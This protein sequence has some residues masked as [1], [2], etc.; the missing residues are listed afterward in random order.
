MATPAHAQAVKSL[1]NSGGRR[2]FVF[3]SFSQK[4]E[5]VE[6]DVYKSLDK[7]KAE[8]SEGSCFFLDCLTEWRELNTAEDFI[9]FYEEMVPLVQTLPL[10]LLHKESIMSNLLSRLQMKARL[11]VEPILRLIAAL[12]RDLLE[13]FVPFLPNIVESVVSLLESGADMEP[14]IIE[15]IFTSLSYIM[16]YLQKYLVNNLVHV[17]KV[18]LKLRYYPKDY[19]QDFMAEA[20]S[21]LLRNAPFDQLKQGVWKIMYEVVKKPLPARKYGVSVLLCYVMR[22]SSSKFHSKAERVLR[23]LMSDAVL[24]I[25]DKFN[26]GSDTV[27]EFNKNEKEGIVV[28]VLILAFQRLCEVIE[29]KDL[30]LMWRCLYGE[31]TNSVNNKYFMRLSCLL[32]L[33]ISTAQIN[34]RRRVSDYL[35][36]LDVVESTLNF[37]TLPSDI[38]TAEDH[39]HEVFEKVLQLMLR[40]LDVLH[41]YNDMPKISDSSVNWA[42]VFEFKNSSLLPSIRE[43]LSKD[44]SILLSFIRELLSK[45]PC[46]L[47]LFR[48]NVLRA[49]NDLIETL[50]GEIS[51]GKEKE[52]EEV[53]YLLLSFFKRQSIQGKNF[54]I[55]V[56]EKGLE[57]IQDFLRSDICKWIGKLNDILPRDL[58]SNQDQETE[59]ALLWGAINCA[60]YLLDPQADS[61]LIINLMDALDRCLTNEPGRVMGIP[62]YH[63]QSIIGAALSCHSKL[64]YGDSY[65]FEETSKFVHLA[66]RHKSCLQVV[67]AVA[68]FLDSVYG[69]ITE[70]CCS[71]RTYHPELKEQKIMDALSLFSNNL[72]HSEKGLRLA[73]LR[74][75]CHYEPL[76]CNNSTED[77]PAQKKMKTESSQSCLADRESFNVLQL[78]LEIEKTP[79]SVS[80]SRTV[81]LLI[82]RVQMALSVGRIPEAYVPLLLNGMI[83]VFHNRFS[84]I[85]TPASEC[86]AVLVSQHVGL[87]WDKFLS[88][89]EQMLSTFQASNKQLDKMNAKSSDESSDLVKQFNSFVTPTSDST[90][91]TTVLTLLLQVLQR[92]PTIVDAR[93]RQIV[94]LFLRFLGYNCDEFV[95]VGSFNTLVC[96]GKEWKSILKEWL[97]LLKLMRNLRS[98]YRNQFLKDLL[99]NRLLDENDPQIQVKVLDCLLIWKDDFLLPYDQHLKN[100]L[101]ADNSF[102]EELT[103]WSLSRESNLIEEH[104]RAYLVPIVIRLL[105]PKVRK[106]KKHDSRKHESRKAVLGFIAHLE[107]DE[108]PLFFVLLIKPLQITSMGSDGT[109]DLLWTSPTSSRDR[110]QASNFLDYFTVDNVVALSWK[111]RN[112][113]LHVI[114]DVIG[115]FDEFR[116]IPFLD[117]LMGCVVRILR[118][119]TSCIDASK[120]NSS[121]LDEDQHESN[122]TLLEKDGAERNLVLSFAALKQ[123]KELRSLCLKVVSLVLN[124]YEDHDFGYEFWDLFFKSVKPLVDNFQQEGSSAEKPSSLF[125]CFVAMTR[126]QKLV[127]MLLQEKNLVP[128]IFSILTVT[129][130]SEDI[131][132]C[133]LKFIEN[134]LNL[135]SELDDK[136]SDVKRVLLPNLESLICSLH[137]FFQSDSATK[138]ELVKCP[139]QTEMRIFKLLSKYIKDPLLAKKFVDILLPFLAKGA[140]NSEIC[141]EAAQVIRGFIPVLGGQITKTILKAVSPLFI[142][143]GRETR[144][145]LC[146]LLETLA[147]VDPSIHNVAKHVHDLN[148]TSATEVG[149]LDYDVIINAY[150]KIN[151]DFFYTVDEDQALVILSHCVYDMSSEE[152]IL[153]HSAY[154]L[155][156]L[157][158]EFSAL[159]LSGDNINPDDGNWTK[160]SL[161]RIVRNFFL[162]HMSNAMKGEASFRKEWI[163]LLREMVMKLTS[164]ANIESLK[165]LIS[166]DDAEIDFFNNIIHLQKHERAR[167]LVHFKNV[168]K[169]SFLSEVI[170]NKVFVPLFFNMLFEENDKKGG[171]IRN[172]CVDALASISGHMK[173]DSYYS[174]LMRCFNE[175]KMDPNKEKILLRLI[176]CIL[177]KFHFSDAKDPEDSPSDSGTTS[178]SLFTLRKCNSSAMLSEIQVCLQKV[179]LPK[180][181]KLLDSDSDKVNVNISLAVLKILKLLPGDIMDSQLPSII[182]R[183]SNF[184]K[185]RL[186][187]VRDEARSCLVACLREL[188]LEYL[189]FIVR[190]LRATLKRGFELH[191]LG[192]T[193]NYILSKFLS[194][195]VRGKLD[196]CLDELLS[197]AENDILGDVAEEKEVEKIASKMKETKQS[198]SFETLKLIAQSV[199]FKSHAMKVLSPVMSQ[200]QK[201]HLTPKVKTKLESMLNHIAAG[202]ECNPSVNQTDLFIFIFGLIEDGIKSEQS[203]YSS[204]SVAG[205]DGLNN[206]GGKNISS[207]RVKGA[208][209]LSSHLITV[210]SLGI[211]HKSVKNIILGKNN[212]QESVKD[213]KLGKRKLKE[214]VKD[215]KHGKVDVQVLSMLD[216][217][218]PLLGICLN[219]KYEDVLSASLRCLTPLVRLPLPS[220][221]SQ[222]DKIKGA[223]FDVAQSTIDTNSSL[224]E[225]CLRLLTLLLG[226]TKVTLSSEELHSLI[227]FPLFV[228]LESNPSSVTLSLLKA[229]V[230]RKLVV[231]EIYDLATK[232]AEL[233]VKSQV[234]SVRKACSE[235]L[236][237]FLL[238]YQLSGKRLQQHLDFLLSNLRY[239]HSSGRIAVLEMLHAIIVKFPNTV[240]DDQSQ[241]LF[242]HLVVC[243][244][245]DQDKVV[246][247]M[248]GAAIKR[249]IGRISSISTNSLNSI[250]DCGISWYSGE[251][252]QLCSAGAQVLSLM[253]ELKVKV[254]KK[255]FQRHISSV[256]PTAKIILKKAINEASNRSL[257]DNT[258]EASIP[259][260]KE[261]YYS[262][263]MLEKMLSRFHDLPLES[264]LEDIWDSVCELLLHPHI[265]VRQVSCRLI[266]MYFSAVT[267]A[268][269]ENPEKPIH[270]YFLMKPSRIFMIAISLCG[271]MKTKIGDDAASIVI[272][273]NLVFAICGV[274]SLMGKLEDQE[275]QKF[276]STLEQQEQSLFIK[277]LQLLDSRKGRS[278][279]LSLT[280]GEYDR[281]DDDLSK[282]IRRLLVSNL[283]KKMGKIA[284]QMEVVQM[285]IVFNSF[286]K[287]VTHMT[288]ENPLL[289][290]FEILLPLYKVCEGFAGKV[291][292]DDMKQLAQETCNRLREKLGIQT[293]VQIYSEIRKSLK[294]KR[295]KRKQEEKVM[296]VVDPVRNAKRKLKNAAKHRAHKKR[297]I[298]GMKFGRWM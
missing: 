15:Q 42:I 10:V 182:H 123:M 97:N 274:H 153:R 138:R 98:F 139:G 118:S 178:G 54:D 192:Y 32:S 83:G 210:F 219:S 45:D 132:R 28:E 295:D 209:S 285:K 198:K 282:D 298:M 258:D 181:Q 263:V 294:A 222:V 180:I 144:L 159:I 256:L 114:E 117:L 288:E 266:K 104:H 270:T 116:V 283:L 52:K 160:G 142:S 57:K 102:R 4:L 3:K 58:S 268:C 224:M 124:K 269:R 101:N 14:E 20:L 185:N 67:S 95:S 130:A 86:L 65:G 169:S 290:A 279:L 74:I 106:L 280:S 171:E 49:M 158:V 39:L 36:M 126:S 23:L 232:V 43:L 223:L 141:F 267:E 107:V 93:S 103:T 261:T 165:A 29:T 245:N 59:I 203:K 37:F 157:F 184:L 257:E 12:S 240:V 193:L 100:L 231:P 71:T 196:Y 131:L 152:L 248:T 234:E 94:P 26:Q 128:D 136:D 217:F 121:A 227:Q 238:G 244:A 191:V 122:Q 287:I 7:V 154:R 241:T 218:V 206:V 251:K 11:S 115:V 150:D 61:S 64:H 8:P 151:V 250:I 254:V 110:F 27:S 62:K 44:S 129:S 253:V 13:D 147:Q 278:I 127:P 48:I 68:D 249:L 199:T 260:W 271:Q 211:L 135:D 289:Y 237:Q 41:N 18:T 233:M 9:S 259:F 296:A 60:P 96:K 177:D 213:V 134:L 179:M 25:G 50:Q 113:F 63:W 120:G 38:T 6:I 53:V 235:I 176:C 264:E 111:K 46:I 201:H 66:K 162:K 291:V 216:P 145:C 252:P 79:P 22:G 75:L 207:G 228:D 255:A 119:C 35:P 77:Q 82:S 40:I 133:V 239:E 92:I 161:M 265:W 24:C 108:L 55:K 69:P 2:R 189:Q 208:N 212:S 277:A 85:W 190:V 143:V 173:W 78:L 73:T 16:M 172:A 146:D 109:S 80:T 30:N 262:M 72:H 229:I 247:S 200:L 56:S 221:E 230:K 70:S 31:I 276:W 33:L 214:S 273:D 105:M 187:D 21:F 137:G 51:Q 149:S 89:F 17:L 225:S 183:I 156:L 186:Q 275:P 226:G 205:A 148:A 88:Y 81:T 236:L 272:E 197:V 284:L 246:R 1:N 286:C 194:T 242:M 243:L 140:Q 99:E 155:L 91:S 168:V 167:A 112:G 297:K 84:Y 87:V 34:D 292:S 281:K 188:G 170:T 19:V 195:P 293:F 204:L 163:Y 164:V 220:I 215:V 166:N 175:M 47:N 174:L 125:S 90:P 76:I 5:D 202:F